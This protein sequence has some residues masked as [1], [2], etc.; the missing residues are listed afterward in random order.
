MNGARILIISISA[1]TGMCFA[2]L[3]GLSIS[4]I[5]VPV[6]RFHPF[7]IVIAAV[8]ICLGYLAYRAAI[9]GKAD[10]ETLVGSLRRGIFGAFVGLILIIAFLF[11]FGADTRALLAH[12]LDQP[13]PG[14]TT[15]RVLIASVLL[16]FGTGFVVGMPR[17]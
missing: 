14:F 6:R 15:F 16:G 7:S 8:A 9:A 1:A 13:A 2:V 10:E 12:A 5:A 4:A 11:M 3:A 17:A